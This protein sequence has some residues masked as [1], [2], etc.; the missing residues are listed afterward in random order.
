MSENKITKPK[1][2]LECPAVKI[3]K[4]TIICPCCKSKV[5]RMDYKGQDLMHKKCLIDWDK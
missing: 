5:D 1:S 3:E 2:C 4:K